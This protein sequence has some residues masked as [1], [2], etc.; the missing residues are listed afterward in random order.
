M[1]K[2]YLSEYRI[3][4]AS[5]SPRR[6]NL[7]K[8][9]DLDFEVVVRPDIE[10][11]YP[12]HMDKIEIPEYLAEQKSDAYLDLLTHNTVIITADTIV[13]HKD[14]VLGKPT[15]FYDAFRILSE[16][17]GS[18]HEVVTGVC[19][20][21]KNKKRIFSALSKVW[22][23]PL[24]DKEIRYYLNNY[25]PYDKAGSYGIQ[26]WIGYAGIDKIEGSFYNVMGL[27][28]QT[29]YQELMKFIPKAK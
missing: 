14:H 7:L 10:E 22:F 23:R 19:L 20:R 29:V 3:I 16:L 27:P 24:D 4:L 12:A 26:E 2:E 18:M 9:L 11:N 25:Q 6:K 1:L 8:G 17:S 21:T 15:D 5:Q 13:W 28:V